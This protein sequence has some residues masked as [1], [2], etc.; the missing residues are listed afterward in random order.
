M[1]LS[2]YELECFQR[3]QELE[4]FLSGRILIAILLRGRCDVVK[5]FVSIELDFLS[6]DAN[7]FIL[8]RAR[9]M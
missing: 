3:A 6:H 2:G 8:L 7:G 5:M 1:E 4:S 9:E